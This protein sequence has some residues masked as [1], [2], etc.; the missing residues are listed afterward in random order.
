MAWHNFGDVSYQY[1]QLWLK[2]PD[3]GDDLVEFVESSYAGDAFL[4][5]QQYRIDFGTV[6]LSGEQLQSAMDCCDYQGYGPPAP[7]EAAEMIYSVSG[8]CTDYAYRSP[9]FV[10]VGQLPADA[11]YYTGKIETPDFRL[12]GN[13]SYEKFLRKEFLT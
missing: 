4:V 6:Y 11:A 1:R 13:C 12:H 9:Q 10:Q 3:P 2:D 8:T 7:L 5:D